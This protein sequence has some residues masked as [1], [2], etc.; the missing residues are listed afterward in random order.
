MYLL[1]LI[2]ILL[3]QLALKTTEE[4]FNDCLKKNIQ[5]EHELEAERLNKSVIQMEL[6][7]LTKLMNKC[8]NKNDKNSE[9][10]ITMLINDRKCLANELYKTQA[11]IYINNTFNR[12]FCK[13][14]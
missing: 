10:D 14:F 8:T 4:K 7:T 2:I 12:A 5:L 1:I 3:S 6:D 11:S 13:Q 9:F